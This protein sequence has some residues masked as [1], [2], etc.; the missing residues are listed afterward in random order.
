ML[1][2]CYF[3]RRWPAK[4]FRL[5][6]ALRPCSGWERVVYLRLAT[7]KLFVC[8]LSFIQGFSSYAEDCIRF[9]IINYLTLFRILCLGNHRLLR[10][11]RS[12][13]THNSTDKMFRPTVV[14]L[15]LYATLSF[16]PFC[17]R[18]IDVYSLRASSSLAHLRSPSLYAKF[19]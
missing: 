15:L 17:S 16:T 1:A 10:S 14:E 4:Y 11:F 18:K 2:A 9:H 6:R 19:N 8:W 3:P 5:C 13:Y 12:R 7:N